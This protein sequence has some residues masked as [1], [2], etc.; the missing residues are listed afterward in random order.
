MSSRLTGFLGTVLLMENRSG[1]I[2]DAMLTP[3]TGT[4]G[5]SA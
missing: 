1:L 4:A 3:A 5:G 2:V